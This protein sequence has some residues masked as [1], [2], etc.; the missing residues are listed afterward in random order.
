MTAQDTSQQPA[1]NRRLLAACKALLRRP[2]LRGCAESSRFDTAGH[3]IALCLTHDLALQQYDDMTDDLAACVN[4]LQTA[5]RP[6]C[7]KFRRY[8]C[9]KSLWS[10]APFAADSNALTALRWPPWSGKTR[11]RIPQSSSARMNACTPALPSHS[12]LC[13]AELCTALCNEV[14]AIPLTPRDIATHA[15]CNAV[16]GLVMYRCDKKSEDRSGVCS[17]QRT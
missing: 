17:G 6:P 4:V 12:P 16:A 13:T 11:V 10:C 5:V 1:S 2:A 9:I 3:P 15:G 14:P 8:A 7:C